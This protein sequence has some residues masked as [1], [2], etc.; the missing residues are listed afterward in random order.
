[1]T[2][3]ELLDETTIPNIS[4][5]YKN[6]ISICTFNHIEDFTQLKE[7]KNLCELSIEGCINSN[8][9]LLTLKKSLSELKD[10]KELYIRLDKDVKFELFD[11]PNN[12]EIL[13]VVS[14][15]FPE[16]LL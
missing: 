2:N 16:R 5:L 7:Y 4:E 9:A 13:Q 8:L 14:E 15:D 11:N 1:M 3:I 6:V 10:F 12:I